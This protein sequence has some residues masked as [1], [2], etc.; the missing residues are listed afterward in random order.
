MS[1]YPEHIDQIDDFYRSQLADHEIDPP[2]G[3][4]GKIS[5]G[6]LETQSPEVKAGAVR[7]TNTQKYLGVIAGAI[8]LISGTFYF[9]NRKQE[10]PA[11]HQDRIP[12]IEQPVDHQNTISAPDTEG[13][14]SKVGSPSNSSKGKTNTPASVSTN[15][16]SVSD[17]RTIENPSTE[18]KTEQPVVVPVIPEEQ[19]L[20]SVAEIKTTQKAPKEKVKFKDKYKKEYQDSTRKI[21]VP[22]K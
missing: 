11:S 9:Y 15:G 7:F 20:D 3:L 12:A 6:A 18:S 13:T 14:P 1:E 4:W 22:G 10:I 8:I 2:E 19:K 21:F 17:P 16:E 5:L